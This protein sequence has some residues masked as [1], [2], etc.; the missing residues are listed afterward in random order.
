MFTGIVLALG[1]I[2]SVAGTNGDLTLGVRTASEELA[3]ARLGDSISVQGVCLTV[4]RLDGAIFYADVSRETLDK[5]TLNRIKVGDRVN[6]EPALRAGD[7]LGGHLVSGHVDAIGILVAA[8]E[9]A[10]SWRMEFEVPAELARFVAPKGSLCLDGV[11]LTVNDV[12]GR[13]FD[14]NIIPHT[15]AVTS[16]GERKVGDP[17]NVE[18]DL[19][20]RY[21]DRLISKT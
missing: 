18:I 19:I 21:L 17:I 9:D 6:L 15:F 4:T 16:L 3:R 10:R 1:E 2:A 11:S 12:R 20:A 14:V 5:T 13:R 7:P 8:R